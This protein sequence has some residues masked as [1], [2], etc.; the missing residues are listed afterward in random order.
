MRPLEKTE[1]MLKAFETKF[2]L[3]VFEANQGDPTWQ[4]LK[5]GVISA[6]S[7]AKVVSKGA[8][9]ETYMAELIAQVATGNKKEVTAKPME[10]GMEHEASARSAYEFMLDGVDMQEVLFSFMNDDFR[11]GCSPDGIIDN[12]KGS[13]I[14][15]PFTTEV[16]VQFVVDGKIKPEYLW[17]V[18]MSMLVTG[19][20]QWDFVQYDPRML[21]KPI[22]IV[23][24]DRDEKK[25]KILE[26]AIPQFI[27][28]MDAKLALFGLTF[29]EQ[30]SRL[31]KG[32]KSE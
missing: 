32:G 7:A 24:V 10:W 13:E 8:G 26:E 19:C 11:V 27:S 23:T 4:M 29:G 17:Q 28:D 16:Y 22:H 20:E 1:A 12:L 6:S 31:T 14:K 2:G 5:L 3:P 9:R 25:I 30:W 18:N 15:C 21:K